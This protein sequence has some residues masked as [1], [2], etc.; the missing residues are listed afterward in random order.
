M[1]VCVCVWG[2]GGGGREGEVRFVLGGVFFVLFYHLLLIDYKML[3]LLLSI[4][5]LDEDSFIK[6]IINKTL[7]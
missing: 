5:N 4:I 7:I 3:F 1:C 2:G 6:K